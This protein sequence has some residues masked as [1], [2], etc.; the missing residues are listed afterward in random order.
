[1]IVS[2]MNYGRRKEA[3]GG[4]LGGVIYQDRRD[5]LFESVENVRKIWRKKVSAGLGTVYI[6]TLLSTTFLMLKQ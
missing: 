1:M 2:Y 6:S 3:S 4:E 5:F